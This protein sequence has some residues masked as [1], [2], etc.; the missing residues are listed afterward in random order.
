MTNLNHGK[1]LDASYLKTLEER[2]RTTLVTSS[3]QQ[4]GG[5]NLT[6]PREER[7]VERKRQHENQ[8]KR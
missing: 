8:T 1:E 5:W 2:M 7:Q 3:Q 6:L 4:V